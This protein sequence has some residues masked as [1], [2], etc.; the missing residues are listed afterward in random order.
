[1][2][3]N[4]LISATSWV[5]DR[6]PLGCADADVLELGC[7]TGR[8]A[9]RAISEGARSYLGVD[10]SQ[11]MLTV[12]SQRYTDPRISFG[13]VDLNAPFQLPRQFDFAMIV[14]VL[15]HLPG[16]DSLLISLSRAIKPGGRL[17]IVDLHPERIAT[18]SVAHFRE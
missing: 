4:S 11:G 16:L 18:G 1:H 6:A 2:D 8:H 13:V 9:A 7:G 12:A 5:F 17:R 14:L 15:E 3:P 10:G